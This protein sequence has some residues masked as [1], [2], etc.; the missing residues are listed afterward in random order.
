[1]TKKSIKVEELADLLQG[2]KITALL[3]EKLEKSLTPAIEE[4]IDRKMD[5]ILAK[6]MLKLNPIVSE[7]VKAA[8]QVH[9]EELLKQI[10]DLKADNNHLR[11]R[12]DTADTESRSLNLMFHGLAEPES[13]TA[14][15]DKADSEALH[16]VLA[17]CNTT[18]G[19]HISD[20]DISAVFRLQRKG[21]EKYSPVLVKFI[22]QRIRR[23]VYSARSALKKTQIYINEHLS[24]SNGLIYAKTRRLVK[25]GKAVSTW[26]FGGSIFLRL[27]EEPGIK[28][29]CIFNLQE[30]DKLF[31]QVSMPP[32]GSLTTSP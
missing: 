31:P 6:I 9:Q 4:M 17:L 18:L 13:E 5:K 1:M 22:S 15:K 12:L 28:P 3:V 19:L 11:A 8:I 14:S 10:S 21:K 30:L 29:T 20:D 25:E 7:S 26:T 27:S 32:T 2:D 24:A 16:A 23:M